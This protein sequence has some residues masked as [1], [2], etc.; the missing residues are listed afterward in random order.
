MACST[1][2]ACGA[3]TQSSPL[4]VGNKFPETARRSKTVFS[5][6]VGYYMRVS[7]V[8]QSWIAKD[9]MALEIGFLIIKKK[10]F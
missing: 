10:T 5:L 3:K 7:A 8:G 4:C 2:P 1:A 6:F 9:V